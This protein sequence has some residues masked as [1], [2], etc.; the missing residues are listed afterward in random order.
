MNT[1]PNAGG[2]YAT[3][4]KAESKSEGRD[5]LSIARQSF[6]ASTDYMDANWRKR[7]GDRI[8]LFQ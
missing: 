8:T 2:D 5:W 6:Q 4:V 1:I 3:V 7:W